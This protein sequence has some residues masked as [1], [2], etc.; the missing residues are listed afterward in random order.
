MFSIIQIFFIPQKKKKSLSQCRETE[1]LVLQNY[2]IWLLKGLRWL[3]Q[4]K[5]STITRESRVYGVEHMTIQICKGNPTIIQ[6]VEYL[7]FYWGKAWMIFKGKMQQDINYFIIFHGSP[8]LHGNTTT[9]RNRS[10]CAQNTMRP[11]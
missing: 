5:Q 3:W 9:F 7:F 1:T 6:Y 4:K 11:R 2:F 10:F 8:Q